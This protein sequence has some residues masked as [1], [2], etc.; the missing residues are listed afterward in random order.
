MS[1]EEY[2]SV[3]YWNCRFCAHPLKFES[4]TPFDMMRKLP[5]LIQLALILVFMKSK[6]RC[7]EFATM[8]VATQLS[9]RRV[10]YDICPCCP[11]LLL[12][13]RNRELRVKNYCGEL[14]LKSLHQESWSPVVKSETFVEQSKSNC[15]PSIQTIVLNN[16]PWSPYFPV[17]PMS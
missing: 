9:T 8:T 15:K 16:L 3:V 2:E 12:C 14:Y 10:H 7:F 13:R 4:G 17:R 11:C 5:C 1:R 6:M